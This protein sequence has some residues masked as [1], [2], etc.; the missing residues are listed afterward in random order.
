MDEISVATFVLSP[1]DN[2]SR[3]RVCLVVVVVVIV[4]V[5][6]PTAADGS[7]HVR[8]ARSPGRFRSF[9]T[10]PFFLSENRWQASVVDRSWRERIRWREKER[11]REIPRKWSDC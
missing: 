1:M 3:A 10:F 2:A 6:E 5:T 7:G 8:L 11:E 9:L 4:A